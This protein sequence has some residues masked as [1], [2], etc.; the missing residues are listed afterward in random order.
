[1]ILAPSG[2]E[3]SSESVIPEMIRFDLQIE[4]SNQDRITVFI[5]QESLVG[6]KIAKSLHSGLDL[7]PNIVKLGYIMPAY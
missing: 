1:M 3:A 4:S 6:E 2:T 7:P 5:A